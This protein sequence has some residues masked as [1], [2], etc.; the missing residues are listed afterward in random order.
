[1]SSVGLRRVHGRRL[2]VLARHLAAEDE[3]VVTGVD[4]LFELEL[5]MLK[6]ADIMEHNT[7]DD[8]WVV[9]DGRVWDMTEFIATDHPG[10][11]DIPLEYGGKDASDFWHEMHGHVEADILE[12]LVAGESWNLGLEHLP[13]LVGLTADPP[14]PEAVGEA[15]RERYI[16]RNW[17]GNVEWTWTRKGPE[18]F[19]EPTDVAHLQAICGTHNKVRVLG[20][21]H[22]V[23]NICDSVEDGVGISLMAHMNRILEIDTEAR[24][25]TAEGGI[26]CS[27]LCQYLRDETP[28]ALQTMASI[29]HATI[30]GS[31]GTGSHG[32]SGVDAESGRAWLP[33]NCGLVSGLELVMADGSARTFT[34]ESNPDVW[35]GLVTSCGRLGIVSKVTFDLVDDYDVHETIYSRIPIEHFIDNFHNMLEMATCFNAFVSWPTDTVMQVQL[36]QYVEPGTERTEP[37][38]PNFLGEGQLGHG[39]VVGGKV[40]TPEEMAER[41][42]PTNRW[43]NTHF[44]VPPN[45]IME[46]LQIEYFVDLSQAQSALRATWSVAKHWDRVV[47]EDAVPNWAHDPDAGFLPAGSLMN[48]CHLRVIRADDQWL[49]PT[50]NTTGGGVGDTLAIAFGLN[51]ALWGEDGSGLMEAAG[52]LERALAPFQAKPHWG[53]LTAMT[54]DQISAL[55]GEKLQ[56]FRALANSMDATAKFENDWS[57][58]F[59]MNGEASS[60]NLIGLSQ[61]ELAEALAN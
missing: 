24:T 38:P 13:T 21:G 48:Y 1:M 2:G 35:P 28:Y 32:S 17:T 43:P 45:N 10:G 6:W 18:S 4:G 46:E 15:G 57:A 7:V 14:P 56:Q 31:I 39:V 9:I 61:E 37:P 33:S 58:K 20:R 60:T 23:H 16:S 47:E 36:Q 25:V 53:K 50:T 34:R 49:S 40:G 52:D 27:Q 29:P 5:P 41:A 55:Y 51:R 3:T 42:T 30:G 54:G 12:D 8:L 44:L 26:T 11:E 19:L 59:L 22:S